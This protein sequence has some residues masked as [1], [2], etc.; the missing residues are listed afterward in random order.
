M[1]EYFL[2]ADT[3]STKVQPE[4]GCATNPKRQ[5][6]EAGTLA[7]GSFSARLNLKLNFL[8]LIRVE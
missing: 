6:E 5:L 4:C 3:P 7:S 1:L 2:G 8:S